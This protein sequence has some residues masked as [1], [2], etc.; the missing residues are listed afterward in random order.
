MSRK[1]S[2]NKS[3]TETDS[4]ISNGETSENNSEEEIEPI[5]YSD[6]PQNRTRSKESPYLIQ[7]YVPKKIEVQPHPFD[8]INIYKI[9]VAEAAKLNGTSLPSFLVGVTDVF[10]G[11]PEVFNI[12]YLGVYFIPIT[13]LIPFD[14]NEPL[15]TRL[16]KWEAN[17]LRRNLDYIAV[18]LFNLKDI[19]NPDNY[20]IVTIKCLFK[21]CK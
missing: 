12:K 1:S 18:K 5:E 9:R 13:Y 19:E 2:K 17:T 4:E 7:N 10:D 6:K 21:N 14:K 11:S 20:R 15:I 8:S 3:Q 16:F